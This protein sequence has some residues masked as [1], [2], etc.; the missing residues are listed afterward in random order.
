MCVCARARVYGI[1][2]VSLINRLATPR[3]NFITNH[4]IIIYI[5]IYI[6]I[7]YNNRISCC[8]QRIKINYI[9]YKYQS[10]WNLFSTFDKIFFNRVSL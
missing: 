10:Y 9:L 8:A 7:L 6:Y 3:I 4:R 1:S 5:Y 2:D